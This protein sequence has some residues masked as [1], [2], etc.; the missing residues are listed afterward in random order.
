MT[1]AQP[2]QYFHLEVDADDL[3]DAAAETAIVPYHKPELPPFFLQ[4]FKWY[5]HG[6][7]RHAE[8]LFLYPNGDVSLAALKL[9]SRSF[10]NINFQNWA[11]HYFLQI[12]YFLRDG[13]LILFLSSGWFQ[14]NHQIKESCICESGRAVFASAEEWHHV[15]DCLSFPL[16]G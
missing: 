15:L 4:M 6:T 8:F 3:A 9:I 10:T 16:P 13:D 14:K 2:A 5:H 12:M 1:Y 11:R 7:S